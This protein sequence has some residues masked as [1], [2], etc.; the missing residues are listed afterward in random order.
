MKLGY[1][2]VLV[3]PSDPNL[4]KIGQTIRKL[5][6]RLAQ[7]NSQHDKY[8]GRIVKK[9]GQKWELKTYITVPDPYWAE[10]IFWLATPLAD[11]PFRG[12]IEVQKMEWEWVQAGLDAAK[13]AG[14]RPPQKLRTKPKRD[15]EWMINQLE[16]TEI[17]IIGRYRG[18]LAGV[19]FQCSNGHIFKKIAR[20]V[21][22][23]SKSCPSCNLKR[24]ERVEIAFREWAD[25][26][27][28]QLVT[29]IEGVEVQLVY[30]Q[31]G[32]ESIWSLWVEPVRG[33]D[34]CWINYL[35]SE[36]QHHELKEKIESLKEKLDQVYKKILEEE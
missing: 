1:L 3:H 24:K 6:V 4:Y 26:N 14:I 33:D 9:T 16:G 5:E 21:A 27:Q 17:T 11:I 12:G 13:K 35:D 7:H 28:L 29:E 2:Y 34:Q 20:V 30:I 32:P 8:A 22:D 36:N 19:E 23:G 18:L 10:K 31:K 15:R 25:D